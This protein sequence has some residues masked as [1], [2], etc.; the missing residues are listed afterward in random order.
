[1]ARRPVRW[2]RGKAAYARWREGTDAWVY[3]PLLDKSEIQMS[4]VVQDRRGNRLIS[5]AGLVVIVDNRI[6]ACTTCRQVF[7][8]IADGK[9]VSAPA[10]TWHRERRSP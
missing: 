5:G 8:R 6:S 10:P 4:F 3:R 9:L 7:A 1:M 2:N